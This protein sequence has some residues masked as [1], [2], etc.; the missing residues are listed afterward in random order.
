MKSLA[1]LAALLLMIFPPAILA[2]SVTKIVVHTAD[3][4]DCGM[5]IFGELSVQVI[6]WKKIFD[7][8]LWLIP[9]F[10]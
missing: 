8:F 10:S 4:E 3:C 6:F 9:F 7:L 1:G 5:S 2:N